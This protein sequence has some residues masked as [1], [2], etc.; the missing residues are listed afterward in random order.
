MPVQWMTQEEAYEFLAHSSEGRLATCGE[1]GQPYI[2]PV[3]YVI[4]QGKLYFHCRK[5]GRK[6]DNIAANPRV[7]FEVSRT[8]KAVFSAD[9]ACACATR[10]TSVLAFGSAQTVDDPEEKAAR[11][12]LLMSR[13]AAGRSFEPVTIENAGACAVVE[14]L[15][16]EITGKRNVDPA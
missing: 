13:Y 5:T 15:I 7:C 14:I 2:T 8:D 9:R 10:Y 12:N 16:D 11:L 4:S 3:N 1:T 6:L